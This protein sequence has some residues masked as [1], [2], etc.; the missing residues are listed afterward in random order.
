M[1]KWI[2]AHCEFWGREEVKNNLYPG[3]VLVLLGTIAAF[4]LPILVRFIFQPKEPTH[5]LNLP[6]DGESEGRGKPSFVEEVPPPSAVSEIIP[7]FEPKTVTET[8]KPKEA[9]I[10]QVRPEEEKPQEIDSSKKT[11]PVPTSIFISPIETSNNQTL[12]NFS[13]SADLEIFNCVSGLNSV[14]INT[15]AETSTLKLVPQLR[16]DQTIGE[17]FYKKT[18]DPEM[19]LSVRIKEGSIVVLNKSYSAKGEREYATSG[20][21]GVSDLVVRKLGAEVI[22]KMK[23][24]KTFSNEIEKLFN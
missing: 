8:S 22:E 11:P 6:S 10:S 5:Q 9:V 24:D 3:L 4:V 18:V 14:L 21:G 12:R 15:D 2:K 23:K 7:I 17:S 20:S 19:I 1:I 13:E 16:L